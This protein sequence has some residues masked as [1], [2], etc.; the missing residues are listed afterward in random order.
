MAGRKKKTSLR[1]QAGIGL[2]AAVIAGG[3]G[4][5]AGVLALGRRGQDGTTGLG[6]IVVRALGL[7]DAASGD[8]GSSAADLALDQPRHGPEDR[9][10]D[11]FRPD[12]TADIP[13]DRREAFAPATMPN[14]MTAEPVV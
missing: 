14:P 6:G 1:R 7:P 9:A 4:V 13:A 11:A 10:P 12:A 2:A 8:D 3:I 5:I